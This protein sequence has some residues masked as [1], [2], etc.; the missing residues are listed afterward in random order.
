M[1]QDWYLATQ[2][3]RYILGKVGKEE[4]KGLMTRKIPYKAITLGGISAI[5]TEA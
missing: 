5:T 4:L 3:R 2:G 1:Y